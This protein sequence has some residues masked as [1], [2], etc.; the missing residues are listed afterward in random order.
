[1]LRRLA[2]IGLAAL[3]LAACGK[4]SS[5]AVA[6]GDG[7]T[8]T[9]ED[10]KARLEEQSPFMRARFNAPEHKKEFLDM[11]VRDEVL[12]RE[13][14]RLGLRNDPEVQRTLRKIM[15]QKM[16]QRRFSDPASAV[17][18]PDADVQKYYDEHSAEFHRPKRVRASLIAW[19]A[20][21]GSP[22]RAKKLAAAKKAL[23]ELQT[24]EKDKKDPAAFAKL[25]AADSEEMASKAAGGDIGLKTAEEVEKAYSKELA[26]A[27]FALK[28]GETSGV[29]ETPQGPYIVRVSLVQDELNR[30]L[31]QVKPQI[32]A[33]LSQQQRAKEYEEWM[34]KLVDSAKVTVDDKALEAVE[35]PAAD[36][37]GAGHQMMHPGMPG[38]AGMPAA[39]TAPQPVPAG[40]APAPASKQ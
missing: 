24:A 27:M 38:H 20:P 36:A 22:E 17:A 9:A 31:D 16:V 28:Q 7:F 6:K 15:V 11:L 8:I 5:P 26:V 21:S 12:A 33:R 14:E 10:L 1:M 34:R 35:M 40:P 4:K 2:L 23:A 29:V 25:V 37:S 19:N 30:T 13:A 18:V 39:P 3:S 32:V